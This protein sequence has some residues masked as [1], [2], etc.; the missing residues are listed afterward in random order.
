MAVVWLAPWP[1]SGTLP[2]VTDPV[3]LLA[4]LTDADLE[5]FIL[6]ARDELT[7]RRLDAADIP[8]L[9]ELGFRDGFTAKGLPRDPWVHAGVVICPGARV[10]VSAMRHDCAYVHLEE[11]WVWEYPEQL[12][13]VVRTL[14]GPRPQMRSISLLVAHEGMELDLIVSQAR[15]GVHQMKQVRSFVV[16]D[17]R[18]E[19]VTAR[20]PRTAYSHR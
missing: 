3:S 6:A 14:P 10:D 16:R 15:T 19:L 13:D 7:R 9:I 8:A 11:V 5:R 2:G 17:G 1:P 18:L 12:E 20:T 4:G